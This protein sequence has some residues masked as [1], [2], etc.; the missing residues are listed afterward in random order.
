MKRVLLAW[1]ILSSLL[2]LG[3]VGVATAD[4]FED[5]IPI[6]RAAMLGDEL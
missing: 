2:A 6:T 1:S 4:G 5:R 3:L